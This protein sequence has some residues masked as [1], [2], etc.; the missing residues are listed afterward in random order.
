[1]NV[2]PAEGAKFST[3]QPGERTQHEQRSEPRIALL[4]CLD[5]RTD[6]LDR[7]SLHAVLR[8]ARRLRSF[9][10]VLAQPPPSKGLVECGRDDRVVVANRLRRQAA[11]LHRAV[12]VIQLFGRELGHLD[13]AQCRADR[14]VDLR[15]VR[16][17]GGWREIHALALLQPP[18]EELAEG[19]TEP[20]RAAFV[21]L[22]NEVAK[23][24]VCGAGSTMERARD[25][26][27]VAGLGVLP[28]VNPQLP[29]SLAAPALRSSHENETSPL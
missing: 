27:R 28:D 10:N 12:E 2:G 13:L 3:P 1:M 23:R 24:V 14:L 26:A 18:I 22:L 4:R 9:R 5:D 15:P 20:V 11:L 7:R 8:D 16:P 29:D 19:V 6:D 17:H 21:V 25:L